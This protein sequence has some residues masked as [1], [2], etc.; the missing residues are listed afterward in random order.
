MT[1]KNTVAYGVDDAS[2]KAAGEYEGIKTLVDAFY[3]AMDVLPVAKK[4]RDMHPADLEM[5]R[6]KLTRFLCGWLGGPRLFREKY[7]P[8]A[9]PSAHSHMPIAEAERDAWLA[10]MEEA[11]KTQPY[12]DDFKKY[13]LVQLAV[14]AERCRMASQAASKSAT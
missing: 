12:A 6:D 7:G 1:Q 8:I 3:D 2:F 4:I 13:L 5:T 11:L 14:P 10:C 9:I